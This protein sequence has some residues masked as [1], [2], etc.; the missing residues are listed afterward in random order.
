MDLRELRYFLAVAET[1]SFTQG[2]GRCFV[3]QPTL[4]AGIGRLEAELGARLFER[5]KHGA[6]MTDAGL[7][8]LP[9]ARTILTRVEAAT[10][11]VRREAEPAF[12]L[13]LQSSLPARLIRPVAA[14]L[15]PGVRLLLRE[16]DAAD[17]VERLWAGRLHVAL[18][19][20]GPGLSGLDARLV[21]RDAQVLAFPADAVPD[22]PITPM[23][24]HG[25]PLIVRTHCPFVAAA[26]AILDDWG[27]APR[28]VF[29]TRS[30]QRALEMVAAGLGPC[31]VPDSLPAPAGVVFRA[32]DGVR[33]ERRIMAVSAPRP[34][35][36]HEMVRLTANVLGSIAAHGDP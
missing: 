6:R 33:L 20:D 12:R 23:A 10:T 28:V 16:G 9:E 14:A 1:G 36:G 15:E 2:A 13:G 27:S 26:R 18:V 21:G 31:L 19:Q 4:S 30:D 5:G 32:V 8:L 24:I 29:R 35:L 25:G 3:T 34:R 11:A 17:L 22:G 7:R